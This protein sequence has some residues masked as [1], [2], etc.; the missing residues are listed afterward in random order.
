MELERY[1]RRFAQSLENCYTKDITVIVNDLCKEYDI[2][3]KNSNETVKPQVIIQKFQSAIR[4][5]N[6]VTICRGI[7]QNGNRCYRKTHPD[8]AEYCKTHE[9]L[10]FKNKTTN[11]TN[12]VYI[13]TEP[14]VS[15][16]NINEPIGH[17]NNDPYV[18][19]N[20]YTSNDSNMCSSVNRNS[21]VNTNKKYIPNL[22]ETLIDD[23]FYYTNTEYIYDKKSMQKV[24]YVEG[25][26]YVLT[27]DPFVLGIF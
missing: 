4:S 15:N 27:D 22:Q 19:T 25:D 6:S 8:N 10:A 16:T 17:Y 21:D 12:K 5:E 13:I 1:I 18:N 26:R 9:Y 11:P 7:S 2:C 23:A 20:T 14:N 24:G 3:Y